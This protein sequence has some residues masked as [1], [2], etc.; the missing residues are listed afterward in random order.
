MYVNAETSDPASLI[1]S[2]VQSWISKESKRVC[3]QKIL[4]HFIL[5]FDFEL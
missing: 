4:K 5:E 2:C 3:D 1:T